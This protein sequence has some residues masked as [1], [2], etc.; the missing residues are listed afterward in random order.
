M[1]STDLAK[2]NPEQWCDVWRLKVAMHSQLPHF[3]V[4]IIILLLLLLLLLLS[5]N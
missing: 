3:P 5:K 4:I 1:R 2:N